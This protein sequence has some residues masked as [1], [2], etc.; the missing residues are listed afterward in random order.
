MSLAARLPFFAVIL[1]NASPLAV[2]LSGTPL[3]AVILSNATPRGGA[4]S[5]KEQGIG[6]AEFEFGDTVTLRCHRER[7]RP[8]AESKDPPDFPGECRARKTL[9]LRGVPRL[10]SRRSGLGSLGMTEY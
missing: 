8:T 2:I 5:W 10:P 7:G 9:R 4:Y 6:P 1:S 3:F